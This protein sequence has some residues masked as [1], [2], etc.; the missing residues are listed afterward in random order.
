MKSRFYLIWLFSGGINE[1]KKEK[2]G[3]IKEEKREGK[4]GEGDIER[5]EKSRK[6][7]EKKGNY[8]EEN[9]TTTQSWV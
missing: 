1:K 6:K 9:K 5:G 3:G 4:D 7:E 2:G 8:I